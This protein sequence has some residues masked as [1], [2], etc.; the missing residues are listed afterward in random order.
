MLHG[1]RIGLRPPIEADAAVFHAELFSDVEMRSR[2]DSRPWRPYRLGSSRAPYA[3]A[4]SDDKTAA[5]SVVE[6]ATGELAGEALLW[7]ID[8]HN[9]VAHI[10]MSLL[11]SARGRGLGADTVRVLCRYGF[12]VLGLQRLQL[13]T[14]AD[15]EAMIRAAVRCGFTH[16]GTLRKAAWVLGA[17]AD[18]V[19]YGQLASE[20]S[21]STVEAP[22]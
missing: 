17:F 16:E 9:R 4:D 18:E 5:F 20:F 11:P 12:V 13:E 22:A 7:G 15:N 2:A 1:E 14:L 8:A 10:G 6:L 21:E 3:D 19:V